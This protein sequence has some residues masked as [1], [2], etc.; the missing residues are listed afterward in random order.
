[1]S[2][3]NAIN[4]GLSQDWRRGTEETTGNI[5]IVRM[6]STPPMRPYAGASS[7]IVLEIVCDADG[8]PQS[9]HE[10]LIPHI[11]R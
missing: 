1:M 2:W 3:E 7:E 6:H 10:R 8:R 5:S 11:D 9:A 4:Y